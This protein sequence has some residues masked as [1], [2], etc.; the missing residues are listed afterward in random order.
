MTVLAVVVFFTFFAGLVFAAA[1][2]W[3]MSEDELRRRLRETDEKLGFLGA[4]SRAPAAWLIANGFGA[5][6]A[7]LVWLASSSE[8]AITRSAT[9]IVAAGWIATTLVALSA[10]YRG[11]PQL[12]V[13]RHLRDRQ[14]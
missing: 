5:A 1:R 4:M 10:S 14:Q 9:L 6:T 3:N 11:W 2:T 8:S 7:A 13:H 12:L